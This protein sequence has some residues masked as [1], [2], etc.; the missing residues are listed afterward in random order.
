LPGLPADEAQ[1]DSFAIFNPDGTLV[2]ELPA[3]TGYLT[4]G[5]IWA[6]ETPL[7]CSPD[8]LTCAMSAFLPGTVDPQTGYRTI[9]GDSALLMW[10]LDGTLIYSIPLQDVPALT[11]AFSPDGSRLTVATN[12]VARVYSVAD[13]TKLA[14]RKYTNGVF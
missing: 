12:G 6:N 4:T 8:G 2:R 5:A 13:G 3:F 10:R 7:A 14:E 1:Q 9:Q 11:V